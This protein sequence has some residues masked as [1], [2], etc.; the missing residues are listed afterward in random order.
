M[1]AI[2]ATKNDLKKDQ[3]TFADFKN[4]GKVFWETVKR[5]QKKGYQVKGI[6][7]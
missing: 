4:E 5:W 7:I 1:I 6:N 3:K 2:M